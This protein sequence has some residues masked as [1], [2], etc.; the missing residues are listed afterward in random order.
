MKKNELTVECT[1]AE[2]GEDLER[3]ICRLF[4]LYLRRTLASDS[5][6]ATA[7]Q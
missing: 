1:F 3:L 7:Y 4:Q 5:K 6:R 2:K